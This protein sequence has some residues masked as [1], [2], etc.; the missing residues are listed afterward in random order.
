MVKRVLFICV[1]NSFRSQ[2]AEGF[3]RR[4]ARRG[5]LVRSGGV[6]PALEISPF[7][8]G[9]MAE[10]GVDI[11]RHTPK[12]V[13]MAFASQAD[14][15]VTMGCS[16]E[17]ACPV[18]VLDRAEEWALPDPGGMGEAEARALRDEIETRTRA[19]LDEL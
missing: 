10:R 12:E 7:A 19:L 9:L 6:K 16:P 18:D 3:A 11:S 2:M 15:I 5:I 13:D 14:R 8:V 1:G 4:Y 17:E